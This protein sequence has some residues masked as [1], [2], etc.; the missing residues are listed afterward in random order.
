[1]ELRVE[2][3]KPTI[4][5]NGIYTRTRYKNETTGEIT[6]SEWK[7]FH[8]CVGDGVCMRCGKEMR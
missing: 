6:F 7:D 3:I 2:L 8:C 4:E 1:M 5:K